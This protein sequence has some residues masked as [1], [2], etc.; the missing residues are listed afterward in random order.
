MWE[1]SLEEEITGKE[2]DSEDKD[3]ASWGREIQGAPLIAFI[4]LE[5]R[6]LAL[7]VMILSWQAG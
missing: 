3:T 6:E 1:N 7:L 4:F 5:K 2:T